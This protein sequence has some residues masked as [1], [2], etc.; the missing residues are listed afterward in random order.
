MLLYVW[1]HFKQRQKEDNCKNVSRHI[2]YCASVPVTYVRGLT[3][4]LM[5]Y[6]ISSYAFV[7]LAKIRSLTQTDRVC[8]QLGG[9]G[10]NVT[11]HNNE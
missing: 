5:V 4:I 11:L 6:S 9:I 10:L 7:Q 8:V 2:Q 3:P 1:T